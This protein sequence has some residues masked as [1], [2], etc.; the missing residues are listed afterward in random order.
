MLLFL[1]AAAATALVLVE[2]PHGLCTQ[3]AAEVVAEGFAIVVVV[4]MVIESGGIGFKGSGRLVII[5]VC[6]VVTV[7]VEAYLSFC[8]ATPSLNNKFSG[9]QTTLLHSRK[10]SH[11]S[12]SE[13]SDFLSYCRIIVSATFRLSATNGGHDSSA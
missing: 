3:R 1:L 6:V 2:L 12:S 4:G 8:S 9:S 13:W 11:T 5:A 7:V 10:S